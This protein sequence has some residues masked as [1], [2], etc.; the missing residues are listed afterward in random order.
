MLRHFVITALLVL[1]AMP[2][3]AIEHLRL[4][5]TTST[6]NSGLLA[7]LLPP[8]EKANDCHIDVIAVGT[9]KALKLGETGDVDVVLVHARSKEDKFVAAGYGVDRRD[10][11]YNDFVILGPKSDPAGIQGL[12]DAV[13]AMTKIALAQ[14]TFV[15]RGD[16]SGTNTRELQLWKAAGIKA[17]GDWY[18]EAGR[19]MGEVLT[20]ADERRGYTLS[21]RGTYLAYRD[22]IDLGVMVEGDKR[23]FNP[24]GVIMVNPARHP[25]VKVKLARKFMDFLTSDTGRKLI[26]GYRRGG[27]Q[28]FYVAD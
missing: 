7:E 5:T 10:V 21:D 26:T 22:K 12:K 24:Y 6:E 17:E 19:G 18:L 8:F 28:L 4:A 11:M 14:A 27:E 20:M 15:S 23:L 3:F 9:G 1:L 25:H 13:A 2:A 16:D